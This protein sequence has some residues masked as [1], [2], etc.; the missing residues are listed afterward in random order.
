M[1][2]DLL[3]CEFLYSLYFQPH[4]QTSQQVRFVRVPT[5]IHHVMV[6]RD[7]VML[8]QGVGQLRGGVRPVGVGVSTT[9]TRT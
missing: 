7:N 2:K 9:T 3:C 5:T 1:I 8:G 4:E 6:S